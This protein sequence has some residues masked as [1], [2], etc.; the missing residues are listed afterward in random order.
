MQPR[1][2][3]GSQSR[4]QCEAAGSSMENMMTLIF[5]LGPEVSP[6]AFLQQSCANICISR[7]MFV[8]AKYESFLVHDL[9]PQ[10][11]ELISINNLGFPVLDEPFIHRGPRPLS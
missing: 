8:C 3:Y 5:G 6:A 1:L 10:H 11:V 7:R 9:S 2:S 4:C